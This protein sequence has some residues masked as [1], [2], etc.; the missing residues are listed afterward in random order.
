MSLL[1]SL[2]RFFTRLSS[3]TPL[4]SCHLYCSYL[5]ILS[6]KL[7][8]SIRWDIHCSASRLF[9]LISSTLT[10]VD[11]RYFYRTHNKNRGNYVFWL[12]KS[13]YFTC[14]NLIV[15]LIT[16][17]LPM[18]SEKRTNPAIEMATA[19]IISHTLVL[20]LRFWPRE[21][22]IKA[23]RIRLQ[24]LEDGK[25]KRKKWSARIV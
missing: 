6:F 21:L 14:S 5:L 10:V 2:G 13:G 17:I 8:G 22:Q 3:S 4:V 20:V 25:R 18:S 11:C 24:I 16:C 19:N 23:K 9:T 7:S 15:H 12:A 1:R